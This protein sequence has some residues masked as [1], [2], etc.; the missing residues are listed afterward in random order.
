MA[1]LLNRPL[2]R[3][4]LLAGSA[5]AGVGLTG[6]AAAGC[7]SNPT[8][9]V[10]APSGELRKTTYMT[11]FGLPGR[12]AAGAVA[13]GKGFFQEAGLDVTIVAGAAGEKNY[14]AMESGQVD[15]GAVDWSGAVPR[16]AK[17]GKAVKIVAAIHSQTLIS[18][19][20]LPSKGIT[21]ARQLIGKKI[22]VGAG[23]APKSVFPAYASAFNIDPAELNTVQWQEVAP[24]QVAGLLIA[25]Q[26]D[27]I[28]LF[29]AGTPGVRKAAIGKGLITK[30][31]DLVVLP[32]SDGLTDL[33]GN[34]LTARTQL[35][36]EQ[37]QLVR[38]FT[39]ALMKGL[40]YAINNPE[41]SAKI[42]A[43]QVPETD[44]EVAAA[45]LTIMKT[46]VYPQDSTKPIGYIDEAR[47]AKG[48]AIL[49]GVLQLP[50]IDVG[51]MIDFNFVPG[52]APVPASSSAK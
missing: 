35:I 3:R 48:A 45:E 34:V 31:Q 7:T 16:Y 5:A 33:M 41:E 13:K 50:P 27:A 11:A 18:M 51:D 24:D 37:P 2:S 15:F 40:D 44:P 42:L 20:T 21:S 14:A 22:G 19:V 28:G 39:G 6:L 36:Q 32:Y 9:E 46:Y 49:E 47:A 12:E 26:V 25:G 1:S 43:E 30:E 38:D 8:S 23:A 29:V 4:T 17:G 52:A 10:A